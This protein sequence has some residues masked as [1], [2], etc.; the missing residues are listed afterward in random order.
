M[1]VVSMIE[2]TPGNNDDQTQQRESDN[3]LLGNG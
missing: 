3:E 1:R 2:M